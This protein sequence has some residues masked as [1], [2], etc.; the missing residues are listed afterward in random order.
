MTSSIFQCGASRR[1]WCLLAFLVAVLAAGASQAEGGFS[2]QTRH[3]VHAPNAARDRHVAVKLGDARVGVF[4]GFGRADVELFNPTTEQFTVITARRWFADFAGAPIPSG[5]ALLVD[6]EHDCIFDYV[7]EQYADTLNTCPGGYVRFPVLVPLPDG[8]VFICGGWD[9]DFVPKADC[10]VFDPGTLQFHALGDLVVPRALHTAVFIGDGRVF[11]AGGF[12]RSEGSSDMVPLDSLE[13]YDVNAGRSARIRTVLQPPRYSHSSVRLLDGR[14]L[15]LGGIYSHREYWLHNVEIF[16]PS[17]STLTAGPFLGLGRNGMQ[18]A[19]LPS[20]RIAVFGGN[21]DA[22]AIEVYCPD[23]GTFELA[24]SLMCDPRWTDFTATNL[25]SAAV[26]LVGGRI[27]VN[28]SERALQKAEIFE[29]VAAEAPSGPALTVASIRQL[30]TDQDPNIVNRTAQWLVTLGPQVQSILQTLAPDESPELRGLAG[31]I[32]LSIEGR[33]YPEVWCVEVWD[34]SGRLKSVWLD[35]FECEEQPNVTYP[36]RH[37]VAIL[38]ELEALDFTHLVVR[39]PVYASYEARVKLFNLVGWTR[40]PRV[41]LGDNL[42]D[43]DLG[44]ETLKYQVSASQDDGYAFTDTFQNLDTDFLRIGSSS[45]AKPPYYMSGMVF[46]NVNIPQGTRILSAHLKIRAHTSRLT[47]AAY[48]MI[49]AEAANNAAAFDS[50]RHIASVPRT[51]A[52]INWDLEHPWSAD[53]WYE[54]PDI[55]EVIQEVINRS[56]WSANNALAILYSTRSEGGYRNFSAYDRGSD[57]GAKLEITYI[58]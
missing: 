48:G 15:L 20:G 58:P 56:G 21:Y 24:Q 7:L 19:L 25:D 33:D 28:A 46:R 4:G 54:S 26:L 35:G 50:S 52:S 14:V 27:N 34:A 38:S 57:Y 42:S 39:F 8:R 44:G 10:A 30:L 43:E 3:T 32:N 16:D 41:V 11:I 55:G 12:G 36:H 31:S 6:G 40:V 22:R 9:M 17:T 13:L 51:S 2:Y 5:N 47:D 1:I 29:E 23:T 53:A 18:T 45:F 37:L 49:Q